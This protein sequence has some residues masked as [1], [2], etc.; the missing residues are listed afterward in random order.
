MLADL[1]L[2]SRCPK[3]EAINWVFWDH[4]N[5]PDDTRPITD[6][7]ECRECGHLWL[8]D[9]EFWI[10]EHCWSIV[11]DEDGEDGEDEEADD[12]IHDH[13][14]AA[15]ELAEFKRVGHNR[16]GKTLQHFIRE[17]AY[18]EKGKEIP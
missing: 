14:W 6:S 15:K 5:D 17:F 1:Y 11:A 9:E 8:V 16:K 12:D 10:D 7:I 4:L 18:P 3:C 13:E 2:K